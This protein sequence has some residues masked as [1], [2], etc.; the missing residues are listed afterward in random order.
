MKGGRKSRKWGKSVSWCPLALNAVSRPAGVLAMSWC[1]GRGQTQGRGSRGLASCS[2]FLGHRSVTTGIHTWK[3]T[4][5]SHSE[6][7]EQVG[8]FPGNAPAYFPFPKDGLP[9]W[10]LNSTQH[11]GPGGGQQPGPH[12][13]QKGRQR[14]NFGSG[15]LGWWGISGSPCLMGEA[16]LW[17]QGVLFWEER[18]R[19]TG[20]NLQRFLPS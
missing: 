13:K 6:E 10:G 1:T 17:S 4:S 2:A 8:I 18:H 5:V 9:V 16:C 20:T 19:L 7:G 3:L 12:L 11:T 15:D 14:S